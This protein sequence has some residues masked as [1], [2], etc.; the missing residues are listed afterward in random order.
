LAH[1]EPAPAAACL[2]VLKIL[3]GLTTGS[4]IEGTIKALP[5]H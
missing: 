5:V 4:L 2:E 1:E 3:G